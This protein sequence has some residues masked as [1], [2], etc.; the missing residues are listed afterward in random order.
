M[1]EEYGANFISLIDEDGNEFVLEH[2]DTLEHNG[3]L[4]MAFFPVQEAQEEGEP[5][6]IDLDDEEYGLIILRA[7]DVDGEQQLVT[8]DDDNELDAVY[9][10]FMESLFEEEEE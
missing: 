7:E 10:A 2:L 5:T 6:D 8:I 1:S 3:A 9:Q 4:Y